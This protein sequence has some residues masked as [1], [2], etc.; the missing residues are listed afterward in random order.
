MDLTGAQI[1]DLL[2]QQ[3]TGANAGTAKKILQ[4]STGFTYT[5]D[6]RAVPVIGRV[7]LERRRR[8]TTTAT[9]RIVAN[10]FL[11]GRWGQLPGVQERHQ[12]VLRRPRHRR[13][14]E[15]PADALAVH[16]GGA[17]RITSN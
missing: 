11:S 17:T 3:V 5:Y 1:Y 15:L 10:N 9:Y 16:P 6:A 8:S 4:V 12:Q 2:E 13:V 7:T 14:R